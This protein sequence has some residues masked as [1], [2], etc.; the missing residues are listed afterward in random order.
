MTILDYL[1]SRQ[2]A[3]FL[4]EPNNLSNETLVR[5]VFTELT[6]LSTSVEDL[7]S[8]FDNFVRGASEVSILITFSL[9]LFPLKQNLLTNY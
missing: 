3:E 8:F 9:C 2:K 7:D 6:A 5:L 1:S 4:L